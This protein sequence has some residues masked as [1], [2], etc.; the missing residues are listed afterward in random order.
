MRNNRLINYH[1]A[2]TPNQKGSYCG[3]GPAAGRVEDGLNVDVSMILTG[4]KR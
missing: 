2:D 3:I 4:S 1:D